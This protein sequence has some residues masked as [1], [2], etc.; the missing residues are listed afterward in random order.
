MWVSSFH[1]ILVPLSSVLQRWSTSPRRSAVPIGEVWDVLSSLQ[2]NV[3]IMIY[4]VDLLIGHGISND[5]DFHDVWRGAI[6]KC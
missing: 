1:L 5:C 6:L 2:I 4:F 3:M